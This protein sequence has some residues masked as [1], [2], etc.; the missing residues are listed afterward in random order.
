[1]GGFNIPANIACEKLDLN[2]SSSRVKFL[3]NLVPPIVVSFK[4]NPILSA[5]HT[6]L[7]IGWY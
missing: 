3:F 1:M 5:D 7:I 2:F 4:E 6:P